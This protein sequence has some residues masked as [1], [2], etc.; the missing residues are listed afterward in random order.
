M[1]KTFFATLSLIDFVFFSA[2]LIQCKTTKAVTRSNPDLSG[3][4]NDFND[5]IE[6]NS[7]ELFEKG[8]AV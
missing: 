1:R 8:K 4:V 5:A 6:Q 7:K 2:F 3:D